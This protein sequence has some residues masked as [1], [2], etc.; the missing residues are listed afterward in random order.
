MPVLSPYCVFSEKKSKWPAA[1]G[2]FAFWVSRSVRRFRLC[3]LLAC[4]EVIPVEDG[5]EAEGKS[6][7]GLPTPEG[8]QREHYDVSLAKRLIEG[9]SA[10]GEGLTTGEFSREE[11]FVGLGGELEDDP[12]GCGGVFRDSELA[13][14]L[15]H[16]RCIADLRGQAFWLCAVIVFV[17]REDDRCGVGSDVGSYAGNLRSAAA[18]ST[19]SRRHGC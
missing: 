1:G 14:S 4:V 3:R 10:I 18:T 19:R 7:L 8:T 15:A 6:S 13:H 17:G 12:G 11:D 5:V 2:P 16:G 9:E